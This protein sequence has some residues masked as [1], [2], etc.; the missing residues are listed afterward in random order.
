MCIY[1]C[2]LAMAMQTHMRRNMDFPLA[3][4]GKLYHHPA[5][6]CVL[7]QL[8]RKISMLC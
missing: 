2:V 5:R 7:E 3:K 4:P 6:K 8:F 1:V